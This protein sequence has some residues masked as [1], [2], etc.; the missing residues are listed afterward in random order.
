MRMLDLKLLRDLRSMKGQVASIALV[1]VC[2]LSVIVMARGLAT[3]IETTKAAYYAE[4][5]FADAFCDLKRSPCS[6]LHAL[7]FVAAGRKL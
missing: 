1:M 4:S 2:G 3:S 7:S 5:R 6:C